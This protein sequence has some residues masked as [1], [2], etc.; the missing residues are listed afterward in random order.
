M[1]C[2]TTCTLVRAVRRACAACWYIQS[3]TADEKDARRDHARKNTRYAP[4]AAATYADAA[5][6]PRL[7]VTLRASRRG[8]R[9]RPAAIAKVICNSLSVVVN[10]L[11]AELRTM[12]ASV[13]DE[14]AASSRSAD[15]LAAS[16]RSA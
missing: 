15:E 3:C 2:D 12:I 4:A 6:L 1:R 11:S 9:A 5:P 13:T 8:A 16:S 14:L 7:P 10:T